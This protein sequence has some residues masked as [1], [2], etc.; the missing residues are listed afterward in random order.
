MVLC[1]HLKR[2]Y[3][4]FKWLEQNCWNIQNIPKLIVKQPDPLA[5]PQT[6]VAYFISY[7]H[8]YYTFLLTC[9][10]VYFLACLLTHFLS[11]DNNP[12]T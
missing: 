9:I 5:L 12:A 2:V 8:S 4:N 10:F 6:V 1:M 7:T 11:P 3:F